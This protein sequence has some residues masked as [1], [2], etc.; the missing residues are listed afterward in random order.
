M[1]SEAVKRST[2]GGDVP[3]THDGISC[4]L[5]LRPAWIAVGVALAAAGIGGIAAGYA[6]TGT[7]AILI[8]A[9]VL[10]NERGTR[11]VRVI[12]SK[13]LVEDER[14]LTNLLIGPRR[15]RVEWPKVKA[16]RVE[17]GRLVA[18]TDAAPFV[19]AQGASADDLEAL[20]ALATE[21]WQAARAKA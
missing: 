4:P 14:L 10:V 15:S 2:S 21:T 1:T 12:H 13:L 17:G 3:R 9:Y 11:R 8:A 7:L 6:C 20:R 16:I 18:E 19:T 5:P